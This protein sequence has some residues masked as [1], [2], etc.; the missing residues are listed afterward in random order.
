MLSTTIAMIKTRFL[1]ISLSPVILSSV[2]LIKNSH[3]MPSS[4]TADINQSISFAPSQDKKKE[5]AVFNNITIRN[6]NRIS[7]G[8]NL[9]ISPDS[10]SFQ[11]DEFDKNKIDPNL[12]LKKIDSR[13]PTLHKNDAVEKL[14][15][16][17]KKP[18]IQKKI[19]QNFAT[20]NLPWPQIM[21][22]DRRAAIKTGRDFRA[23]PDE[24]MA[25]L[26]TLYP[27]ETPNK[28]WL[29]DLIDITGTIVHRWK[30]TFSLGTASWIYPE[31]FPNGSIRITCERSPMHWELIDVN[32]QNLTTY[33]DI[34][35]EQLAHHNTCGLN[36]GGFLG[37]INSFDKITSR[38]QDT[39]LVH[40]SPKGETLQMVSSNQLLMRG[41]NQIV[42]IDN[43]KENIPSVAKKGAW[44]ITVKNLNKIIIVDP[45]QKKI[46][47]EWGGT[48]L[49]QPH[50]ASFLGT[51]H[52]LL[53]DNS[54]R[55][56]SSRVII[57]DVYSK[58]I[59]WQYGQKKN[60]TIFS[61]NGGCAQKLPNKNVLISESDKGHFLEV[62]PSGEIVWEG[63]SHRRN[64]LMIRLPYNFFK[65]IKFNYGK[66]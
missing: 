58:K 8:Y 56:K 41:P 31:P 50:H 64:R 1:F 53:F 37:I 34:F 55:K 60:Q 5:H 13:Q 18:N 14:N 12:L 38:V 61:S 63:R 20:T 57:V 33:K 45:I 36:D 59:I 42:Y 16:L 19:I 30:S 29:I 47:W 39:F 22:K 65:S 11:I 54:I 6:K 4:N 9:Y 35:P 44:L 25:I 51:Q 10:F 21:R 32:S 15:A 7:Y 66:I 3:G 40:I 23:S 17:L 28:F 49:N 24:F 27:H 26:K 48:V 46:V 52:I 2:L 62:T 43:L